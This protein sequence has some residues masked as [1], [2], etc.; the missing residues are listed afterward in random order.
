MSKIMSAR[1]GHMLHMSRL[2]R[3][4]PCASITSVI[5]DHC[6]TSWIIWLRCMLS[7]PGLE[8]CPYSNTL[9]S[10]GIPSDKAEQ[11]IHYIPDCNSVSVIAVCLESEG[12]VSE[13]VDKQTAVFCNGTELL[14]GASHFV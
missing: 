5:H 9:N 12:K 8:V 13:H 7:P 4:A 2:L 14:Y 11:G 6:N 10:H 1:Q 3:I